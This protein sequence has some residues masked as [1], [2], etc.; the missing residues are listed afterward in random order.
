MLKIHVVNL[1]PPSTLFAMDFYQVTGKGRIVLAEL[2]CVIRLLME[3]CRVSILALTHS[4]CFLG[5]Q[6]Q[7]GAD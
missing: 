7:A 2:V 5:C 6:C 3:V 4:R 1:P